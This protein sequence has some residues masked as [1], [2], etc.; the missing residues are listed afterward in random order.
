MLKHNKTD[1]WKNFNEQTNNI[2][3]YYSGKTNDWVEV[4]P[5]NPPK[6]ILDT[7]KPI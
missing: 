5:S 3:Q 4:D 6:Q 2:E 1:L 7:F